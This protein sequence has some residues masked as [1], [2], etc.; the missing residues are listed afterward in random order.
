MFCA[1]A[2][3]L[4]MGLMQAMSY[5]YLGNK[6]KLTSWICATIAAKS[7]AVERI[8]DPMCGTGA[9]AEAFARSGHTVIASDVLKF[10][11]LHAKARLQFD[12][13]HDFTMVDHDGYR[14]AINELN[15]LTPIKGFFWR[16][17]SADGLPDNGVDPRRYFTGENAGKIDA[18][19][20]K[21]ADW[22][23][24][25]LSD[26]ATDLLLHD[27]ILAT[28]RVANI[29]G[30]Y[31]YFRSTWNRECLQPI[32]LIQSNM[33]PCKTNHAVFNGRAEDLADEINACDACYLDPPYT[34]RQYGGNYHILETIAQEDTPNPAGQG[35][36]RNWKEKASD[37]CYRKK[38]PAAFTN[39]LN[40]IQV[41]FVFISYS[42]DGQVSPDELNSILE[43]FGKV[44]RETVPFSRFDSNGRGGEKQPLEE[45]L[46]ILDRR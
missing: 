8:A 35:G 23:T 46:Y 40:L 39:L 6:T 18:I 32:Q 22:R 45:H 24:N 36:L 9:V 14:S 28:N 25:G 26:G 15:G 1:S 10:P 13:P 37:F 43:K 33:I 20:K 11:T 7:A 31:G 19:R 2:T 4:D 44:S 27:L 29:T 3:E 41:P 21:V 16:E 34:K 30:T 42:N 38:A 12:K 17:Y 5:R